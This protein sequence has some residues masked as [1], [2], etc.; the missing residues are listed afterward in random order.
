M[1]QANAIAQLQEP[2]APIKTPIEAINVV[3][4]VVR[5]IFTLFL[6][7]AVIFVIV[8][9]LLYLTAAGNTTRL[10]QAKSTLIYSI[11]AIVIALIAGGIANFVLD[12]L[13]RG[14][15]GADLPKP[16]DTGGVGGAGS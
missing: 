9:A 10:D 11:V 13:L 14:G 6:A 3:E 12:F 15:A 7:L 4:R 5:F 2:K 16:G 8:S 1:N